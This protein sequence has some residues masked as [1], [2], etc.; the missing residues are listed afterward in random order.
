MSEARLVRGWGVNDLDYS[1]VSKVD[2]K[3]RRWA[4]SCPFYEVWA[5]IL[6]R[7]CVDKDKRPIAYREATISDEWRCVS[8]FKA[9]MKEQ[10]W[11]GNH[12]DKDILVV[13]NKEYGP[14]KCRFV[15]AYINSLLSSGNKRREGNNHL[16]MGVYLK[17]TMQ[18]KPYRSNITGVSGEYIHLGYFKTAK[19]AHHIWQLAKADRI[20]KTVAKYALEECFDTEVADSLLWRA[21][22]LRND[23][24]A[25]VITTNL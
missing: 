6:A 20:E 24:E 4:V 8:A 23:S 15:P 17:K 16:P 11:E 9:W 19:E 1:V 12:C 25:G 21:W 22:K 7:T 10:P 2:G 13:G 14:D 5:G 3:Q 18:D